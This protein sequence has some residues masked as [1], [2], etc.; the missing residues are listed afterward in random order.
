MNKELKEVVRVAKNNGAESKYLAG[1]SFEKEEKYREAFRWF[2]ESAND[3]HIEAQIKIGDYYA[4]GIFIKQ[5]FQKSVLWYTR[6]STYGNTEAL[7]K[8]ANL[9]KDGLGTEKDLKLAFDLYYRASATSDDPDALYQLA[10][11]AKHGQGTEKDEQSAFVWFKKA[12]DLR[13]IKAMV[14]V[15]YCYANG[16]GVEKSPSLAVEYYQLAAS[17]GSAVAL[18]NLGVCYKE[19]FGVTKNLSK[20]IEVFRKA[21]ELDHSLSY[22]YL[23]KCYEE[24]GS[25]E[26]IIIDC[27]ENAYAQGSYKACYYLSQIYLAKEDYLS[28]IEWLLKGQNDVDCLRELGILCYEGDIAQLDYK[29][30]FECFYKAS[31]QG[32]VI[33][34][35]YMALSYLNGNG[36]NVDEERGIYYLEIASEGNHKDAMYLLASKIEN[37]EPYKALMLL[38]K[39][40]ELGDGEAYYKLGKWYSIG[41]NVDKDEK[42]AFSYYSKA[43]E[44]GN[45]SAMCNLG[46]AYING[47]GVKTCP[48]L[49]V[50]WF[51]RASEGN[52]I[53]AK[54]NLAYCH[55]FGVGTNK[56]LNTAINYYTSAARD[57]HGD[58]ALKLGEL[59]MNEESVKD[60]QNAMYW[61]NL[62]LEKGNKKAYSLL[63]T[64]YGSEAYYDK[65][66]SEYMKQMAGEI[67]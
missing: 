51:K 58:S 1:I 50:Y 12:S 7:I 41:Y 3:G 44:L 11:M 6:A 66:K 17:E 4:N 22:T 9:Y 64:I 46:I 32:D 49:G 19:G 8:L 34:S 53:N 52:I 23:A 55:E 15:G 25:D 57:G 61:L 63:S 48:E 27:Y 14:N 43:S 21:S 56:D 42:K 38:E 30:A 54:F 67:E 62:A 29:K 40:A 10:L 16:C 37:T 13:H 20:A 35:Y 65:D 5:D 28:Q 18:F 47:K 33:S 24:L 59:Y 39:C 31:E 60:Y 2:L 26:Q 36:V 45:Y